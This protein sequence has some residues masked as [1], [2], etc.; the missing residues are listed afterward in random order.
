MRFLKISWQS[1]RYGE[2][3]GDDSGSGSGSGSGSASGSAGTGNAGGDPP[4]GS[5]AGEKV[6]KQAD[7]DRIVKD[8]LKNERTEKEKLIKDL[9]T[10]QQSASLTAE[11][12]ETLASRIES[13]ESSLRTKEEQ[14]ALEKKKSEDKFKTELEKVSGD[15]DIWRTRFD[16]SMKKRSLLDAA[17]E[18]N[19]E[20]PSQIIMM[21]ESLTRLEEVVDSAGKGTGDFTTKMKFMGIDP[22]SKKPKE[23][24][25][26]PSEALAH[27]RENG[28]HKNLF[29]HGATPGT[30]QGGGGQGGKATGDPDKMPEPGD[31]ATQEQF[32]D[33]YN[34]WRNK[35]QK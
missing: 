9:Q 33:A 22:E 34:K 3:E 8:R 4:A 2:G 15:R 17:V 24:D 11:E 10:L 30:G 1:I 25:L 28:L 20:E 27:M 7:V 32:R 13:M 21:F 18:N 16:S 29:K 23:Y 12:K 6:F 14:F 31:Y 19:V 26:P 35:G 5:G